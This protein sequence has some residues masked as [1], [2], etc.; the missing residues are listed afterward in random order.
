[1]PGPDDE[2]LENGVQG[3]ME[4]RTDIRRHCQPDQIVTVLTQRNFSKLTETGY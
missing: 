2:S 3:A 1:M 4:Q